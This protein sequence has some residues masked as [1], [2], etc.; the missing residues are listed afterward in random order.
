MQS[1]T[2]INELTSLD[3]E[4]KRL[5]DRLKELRL[6]R[7]RTSGN[8]YNYMV[9]NNLD[10]V[11]HD[12][13]AISIKTIEPKDRKKTKPKK[14]RRNDTINLCREV[15]IPNPTAFF[16]QLEALKRLEQ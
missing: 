9:R 7:K 14:A 3:K 15:G 12:K 13:T 10:T 5:S 8:L 4:I 11:G 6:Q 1:S 2:Y 16:E